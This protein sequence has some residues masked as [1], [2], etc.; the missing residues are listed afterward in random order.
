MVFDVA[1]CVGAA[2]SDGSFCMHICALQ[3]DRLAI[4]EDACTVNADITEADI[5]GQPVV[6]RGES[7]FI[8][9]WIVRRPES[10]LGGLDCEACVAIGIGGGC[11]V[12]S[13]FRNIDRNRRSRRGVKNV[14]VS[15][16]FSVMR[17]EAGAVRKMQIVIVN[18]GGGHRNKRDVAGKA[19]VVK[20]IN[21]DGRNAIDNTRGIDRNHNKV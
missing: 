13:C 16:D 15:G 10:K 11:S 21:A 3:K 18:E 7:D 5:I 4:Q 8:E 2:A 17:I 6:S 1:V 19:S 14:N 20:P 12:G 9:L